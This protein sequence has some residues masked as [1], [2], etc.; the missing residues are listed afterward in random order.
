MAFN[1]ILV[2]LDGSDS[3]EE[4]MNMAAGIARSFG[5]NVSLLAVTDSRTATSSI[6]GAAGMSSEQQAASARDYLA[7]VTRRLKESGTDA[8]GETRDGVPADTILEYATEIGADLIAVATHRGSAI[9][10]GILG[11]VTDTVLRTSQIPV[12][13]VNPDHVSPP[14][15]ASWNPSTVV[16]PLDGSALAEESVPMALDIA[17]ACGAKVIFIQ[18]VH[19]P[20][21]AVSGPGAEYYDVDYGIAG[22]REETREYLEKFVAMAAGQGIEASSHAALGN[23]AARIIEETQKVPDALVVIC[24]HGSGGFRRMVQGSVADKLVR[25][26]HHP[27]IVLKQGAENG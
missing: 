14:G 20:G 11:S 19:I 5:A 17:K 9:A 2:A 23:A 4:A 25:A 16:V 3:S 12:L 21:F 22:Q 18:A 27:V 26:S 10:R 6:D 15:D 13:A 8:T 24:S 1:K 7:D